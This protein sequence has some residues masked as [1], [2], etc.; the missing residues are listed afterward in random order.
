MRRIKMVLRLRK[1]AKPLTWPAETLPA[2]ASA[3][4]PTELTTTSK[5]CTVSH[6]T[7]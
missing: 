4:L 3:G 5:L 7:N 1:V 6:Q 2:N